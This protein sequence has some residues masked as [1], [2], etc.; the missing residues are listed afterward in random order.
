MYIILQ[1]L[2][3]LQYSSKTMKKLH[4]Q[5]PPYF[6]TNRSYFLNQLNLKQTREEILIDLDPPFLTNQSYF[7]N[8]RNLW[9]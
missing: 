2:R 5:T 9:F 1:Y 8:Q 7:L 4:S 3:I 6:L